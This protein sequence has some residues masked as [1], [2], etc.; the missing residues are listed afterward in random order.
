MFHYQFTNLTFPTAY[1]IVRIVCVCVCAR[2]RVTGKLQ[3]EYATNIIV[4]NFWIYCH[5]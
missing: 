1:F 3:I 4:H 2:A 5:A